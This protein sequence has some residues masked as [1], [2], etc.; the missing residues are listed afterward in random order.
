VLDVGYKQNYLSSVKTQ[1]HIIDEILICF[2]HAD[3][4][5]NCPTANKTADAVQNLK[6]RQ[7]PSFDIEALSIL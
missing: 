2:Q 1:K 4:V 7:P 3:I 6:P 5:S